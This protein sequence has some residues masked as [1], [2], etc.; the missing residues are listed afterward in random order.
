MFR[1][2][3]IQLLIG[4]IIVVG[5]VLPPVAYWLMF[6]RAPTISPREARVLLGKP[7]S[8]SL[9][10]DVRTPE[11]FGA[12]HLDDAVNW[13]CKSIMAISSRDAIPKEFAGKSLLLICESGLFSAQ[14]AR[15][16]RALSVND[17]WNICGGA[18]ILWVFRRGLFATNADVA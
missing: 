8:A 18:F 6:G 12:N 7:G 3:R 4:L 9:L 1:F 14:A 10:V 13:P 5:G 15:T 16:L 11:E 17:L 2:R